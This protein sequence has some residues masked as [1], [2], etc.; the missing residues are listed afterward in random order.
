MRSVSSCRPP[1]SGRKFQNVHP[2]GDAN[3]INLTENDFDSLLPLATKAAKLAD[4][5]SQE[6]ALFKLY[7]LGI[8]TNRDE[9]V[10][11]D[12]PEV[13]VEKV[14]FLVDTYNAEVTRSKGG[15]RRPHG[16]VG[17]EIKWTRAVKRDLAAGVRYGTKPELVVLSQ[18]RRFVKRSL[19]MSRQLNEMLYQVPHM[20]GPG[21]GPNRGISFSA[22]ERVDF[23]AIAFD[24]VPNKDMAQHKWF[25]VT[26][27]L[28]ME[29]APTTSPTGASISS[30]STTRRAARKR[31]GRSQR[32]RSSTTCTV[33]STTRSI[34]R[35]TPLT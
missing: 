7:S 4:K 31:S 32:T 2:D 18:Y 9:W 8:V 26:A 35:N 1:L 16:E 13:V 5:T 23:G 28:L 15:D 29:H 30:R 17:S 3:W 22:E 14:R 34:G 19:Y 20:F 21:T 11:D 27:S 24:E 6:R 12:D 33:S 25:R 10:Y